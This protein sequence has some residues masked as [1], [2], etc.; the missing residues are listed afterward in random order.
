MNKIFKLFLL[1]IFLFT[2]A[3]CSNDKPGP[4]DPDGGKV[5]NEYT[6]TWMNEEGVK[7]DE[8]KV[9]ED[10]L[11]SYS[12]SKTNT[13][14]WEYKFLGWSD[15]QNG[16]V[17]EL[18]K[19]T[20][21]KTYFAVVEKIKRKYM[22]SFETNG[23]SILE[24]VQVEYNG[25]I[26]IPDAP[27]KDSHRFIGWCL[28][29]SLNK[30]V[31]W[32]L[33]VTQDVKLYA[34]W[35]EQVDIV[36]YLKMLLE[37]YKL[38]PYTYIPDALKPGHGANLVDSASLTNDY[39]NFVQI[40]NIKQNGFGEQWHMVTENLEQSKTFFNVLSVVEGLV[41]TSVATFNNYFDKNPADTA[42]HN[43][44]SGIYSITVNF[45][46]K[47]IY[48]VLDYTA[49]LPV[50][51]EQTVQIALSMNVETKEKEVR[52]Q[53]GDANA[54]TYIVND[55]SY[56]F[57]IKYLGLRK[58]YFKIERENDIVKGQINEFLT[59]A[60]KGITSAAEFYIGPKYASVVGNKA[61]GII[62]FTGYI[63][64]LY[65]VTDGS[66]LGYEVRE[67][68][69]K[70][71]YNTLWFKLS[72]INGL[73]SIKHREKGDNVDE[74]IFV[75]GQSTPFASKKVGGFGT[76]MLSRRYDI[77][78]RTQYFYMYDASSKEYQEV[79]I[80]V[81]MF[82]VQEENFATL[83]TDVKSENSN[84]TIN[85]KMN[86]N[87]LTKV[88]EDYDTLIDQFIINKE[89]ISEDIIVD[90]IGNKVVFK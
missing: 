42:N 47:Q 5:V 62:G 25:S 1:I 34:S 65:N 45:D 22:V 76:K 8:T 39:S 12:Y 15:T 28:D 74:A 27:T 72:D 29:E 18:Q 19:P 16:E 50:L 80:K 11:P 60:G 36:G 87:D 67:T 85:V 49:T 84:L 20:A 38:D 26:N 55:N 31:E 10:S 7:L 9:K 71:E 53:L 82:F 48:Y 70:I 3:S 69:S 43:F 78:Y 83:S 6:I 17:V 54:L 37:G 30:A 63:N 66:L 86:Q 44:A 24:G 59:V 88:Q 14:E 13:A 52:I 68:L 89:A 77:E 58:A 73:T 21:D 23:G 40:S 79:A 90:V 56:T 4:I 41:T 35:N 32:P 81:P 75:N 46:G 57:A 2:F 51:G 61:G 64:E 33:T